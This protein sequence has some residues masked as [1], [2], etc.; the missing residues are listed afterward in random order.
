MQKYHDPSRPRRAVSAARSSTA[1]STRTP[2]STEMDPGVDIIWTAVSAL[3]DVA[4]SLEGEHRKGKGDSQLEQ[5]YMECIVT[6]RICVRRRHGQEQ[7]WHP[8][9][10]VLIFRLR[11]PSRNLKARRTRLVKYSRWIDC[12]YR[13]HCPW[14]PAALP[15]GSMASGWA[16][17]TARVLAPR[18]AC[19]R[20][21]PGVSGFA[22]GIL[23]LDLAGEYLSSSST[24]LLSLRMAFHTSLH[25]DMECTRAK[26]RGQRGRTL[27]SLAS[28]QS[29]TMGSGGGRRRGTVAVAGFHADHR[30]I[31]GPS[32]LAP[33]TLLPSSPPR[34]FLFYPLRSVF[35][36]I[37]TLRADPSRVTPIRD[38]DTPTPAVQNVELL[39]DALPRPH[40]LG[41]ARCE[42][43]RGRAQLRLR[44]RRR[45]LL[46]PARRRDLHHLV[47]RHLRRALPCPR[48]AHALARRPALALRVR[49]PLLAV[50]AK[51]FGSGVIIAT[52]FIHLL[53]PAIDELSSPCLGSGWTEYVCLALSL[54]YS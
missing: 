30:R 22:L 10:A 13:T 35:S 36:P 27:V 50:F 25:V 17:T 34:H 40:R 38:S 24:Y 52:A 15:A 28:S 53:D 31:S 19:R 3:F 43:G 33:S 14:C 32:S 48:A 5:Y 2:S 47:R 8:T 46:R 6:V 44:R 9:A 41:H 29:S 4:R 23:P 20:A 1:F 39:H 11:L 18:P 12:D 49:L 54:H 7:R 45:H 51:Y 26:Q 16:T 37:T 42:R 21:A